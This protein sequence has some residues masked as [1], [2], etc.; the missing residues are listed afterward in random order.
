MPYMGF[1]IRQGRFSCELEI[2]IEDVIWRSRLLCRIWG[3]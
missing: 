3:L 1:V 2:W